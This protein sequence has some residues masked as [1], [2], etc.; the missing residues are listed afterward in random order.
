MICDRKTMRFIS[1]IGHK[2]E[3]IRCTRQNKR[4]TFIGLEEL[5]ISLGKTD[6]R[7]IFKTHG[8]EDF[9]CRAE[10]PFSAVNDDEIRHHAETVVTIPCHIAFG[11]PSPEDFRHRS[12]VIRAFDC[13]D[14]ETAGNIAY[15]YNLYTT[16]MKKYDDP[17]KWKW[18]F[19]SYCDERAVN[20]TLAYF[21]DGESV[22]SMNQ[23]L[24]DKFEDVIGPDFLWMYPFK[25]V[26]PEEQLR[27]VSEEWDA[28]IAEVNQRGE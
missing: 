17:E 4:F 28:I 15:A 22:I 23:L 18:E 3:F 20:E 1:D 14:A 27:K 11:K 7:D 8:F 21:Q 13:F 2:P 16:P 5:F 12:K 6:D 25:E 10:L 26:T 9:N 24:I 19:D